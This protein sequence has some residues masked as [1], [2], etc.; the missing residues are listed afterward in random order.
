MLTR[1]QIILREAKRQNKLY[2][3]SS[4]PALGRIAAALKKNE[5]ID[6]Y[7]E[8][9]SIVSKLVEDLTTKDDDAMEV[10]AGSGK[11]DDRTRD[12][13]LTGAIEAL[14]SSFNPTS[15]SADGELGTSHLMNLTRWPRC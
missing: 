10:D 6:W 11:N 8:T 15:K 5:S 13:I 9:L 3:Q 7:T 14:Q 1:L 4:I 12:M 2:Q